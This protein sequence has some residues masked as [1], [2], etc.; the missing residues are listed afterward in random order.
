MI[1]KPEGFDF[2]NEGTDIKPKKGY[3]ATKPGA[4]LRLKVNTK[5]TSGVEASKPVP[6]LIG[7]L[8]SYAHM[9]IAVMACDSGC[10]CEPKTVDAHH[11]LKQSTIYLA[12]LKA[13]QAAECII[14]V[15][16]QPKSS[17]GE[18]KFKVSAMMT[19][20]L[21]A[22]GLPFVSQLEDGEWGAAR[23]LGQGPE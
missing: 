20:G 9:G 23:H 10:T 3:V 16:V 4:V 19:P 12:L 7:Y 1:A 18:N 15:T 13:T 2:V 8:K 17:S 21:S 5:Q 11:E 22:D 6:V 14:S